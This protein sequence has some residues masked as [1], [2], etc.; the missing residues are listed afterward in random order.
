MLTEPFSVKLKEAI[1]VL[2][3]LMVILFLLVYP[4]CT[5]VFLIK[6]Q[7]RLQ[8]PKVVR[9]FSTLYDGMNTDSKQVRVVAEVFLFHD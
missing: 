5:M 2:G 9:Q 4:V 8:E 3:I 7:D 6:H 1:T